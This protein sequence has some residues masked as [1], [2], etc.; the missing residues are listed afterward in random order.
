MKVY[1]G[2][3]PSNHLMPR[4]VNVEID[5][6][7][8][9]NMYESLGLI[10][11]PMLKKL[12]EG[13]QGAPGNMNGFNYTTQHS[14]P[15]GSFDFYSDTDSEAENAG[16]AEWDEI[17][18]KMIWSFE[19]LQTDWEEQFWV[20]KPEI[21]FDKYPEDEGKNIFPLRWKVKGEC[22]WNG[23]LKHADRIQEG[24]DLFGKYFQNLWD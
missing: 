2:G 4:L 15:Q 3:Y 7:D 13:K 11:L 23:R 10:I 24:F 22:D 20:T 21:D 1:I 16:F 19:Q 8:V 14:W 17:M 18:D 5:D 6:Y 12:K 9:W